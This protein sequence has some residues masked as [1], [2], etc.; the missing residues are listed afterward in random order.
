[1]GKKT[2]LPLVL[3]IILIV[4]VLVVYVSFPGEDL[5]GV[6]SSSDSDGD[7]FNDDVDMFPYD[8]DEWMDLDD[9]GIGDNS[10]LYINGDA[11]VK[12]SIA[13]FHC[14]ELISSIPDV[15]F[16]IIVSIYDDD[17]RGFAKI[18]EEQSSVYTDITE[19]YDPFSYTFDVYDD[20]FHVFVEIE[21]WDEDS[22]SQIDL[23]GNSP[24][25]F[26]GSGSFYP[27]IRSNSSFFDDGELDL[28]ADE[29][30]GSIDF[31]VELVEL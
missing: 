6:T 25:I 14:E 27:S 9:D 21:A 29:F 26:R 18:G 22:G 15:Y 10:D 24:S 7:G 1:M 8:E 20:V 16:K 4:A 31:K 17:I 2:I 28:V 13:E 12:V 19:V 5:S 11:G 23:Y 3:V 30:D